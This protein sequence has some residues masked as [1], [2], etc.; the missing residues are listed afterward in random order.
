MT[1]TP[2]Q[3]KAARLK[4]GLTEAVL[5]RHLRLGADPYKTVCRWENGSRHISGPVEVCM[6]M[7]LKHGLLPFDNGNGKPNGKSVRTLPPPE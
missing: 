2:D 5:G 6:L 4:L 3:F 7:F 1:M